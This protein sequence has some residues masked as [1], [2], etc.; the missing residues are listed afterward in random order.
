MFL[1]EFVFYAIPF[2]EMELISCF[3]QAPFHKENTT[4]LQGVPFSLGE[5]SPETKQRGS[6]LSSTI[7]FSLV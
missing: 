5:V 6:L 7:H 4:L 1:T 2:T 3:G